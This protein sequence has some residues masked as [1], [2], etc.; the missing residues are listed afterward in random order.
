MVDSEARSLRAESRRPE[1]VALGAY[2]LGRTGTITRLRGQT[3]KKVND[4][5]GAATEYAVTAEDGT[6]LLLQDI[7]WDNGQL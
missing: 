5:W 1:L 2:R 3:A 7:R 4:L 6:D